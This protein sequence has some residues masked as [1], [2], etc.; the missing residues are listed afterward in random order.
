MA[1]RL[2]RRPFD[3]ERLTLARTLGV[4][5]RKLNGWTPA[6][7]HEHYDPDGNLTGYTV[8]TREPEWSDDDR[9]RLLAL[10]RFEGETCHGCGYHESLTDPDGP[11]VFMPATRVCPVCAGA[12]QYRRVES[13]A[14]EKA[15]EAIKGR[16]SR[17]P[18][19]SDGRT[20]YMELL[21]PVRAEEMR[22]KRQPVAEG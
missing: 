2:A 14:D 11:N 6:E 15:R 3:R 22:R 4:S 16:P 19:P 5:P 17:T 10:A 7:R 21:D 18:L 8:V 13:D 20:T 12:D 1:S 9:N